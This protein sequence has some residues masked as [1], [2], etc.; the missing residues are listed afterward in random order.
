M[1]GDVITRK[2][3][4]LYSTTC[5]YVMCLSFANDTACVYADAINGVL[6]PI[7]QQISDNYFYHVI[8]FQVNLHLPIRKLILDHI[9]LIV[10]TN[11]VR[12]SGWGEKAL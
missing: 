4:R 3:V 2:T 9:F 8:F 7:Y 12:E 5:T 10:C 6:C 1:E 11:R